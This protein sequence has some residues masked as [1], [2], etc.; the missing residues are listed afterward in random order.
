V[1]ATGKL[2]EPKPGVAEES[3]DR[4]P[5]KSKKKKKKREKK[6]R[7]PE[8]PT[9]EVTISPSKQAAA[10]PRK[11][12]QRASQDLQ[13]TPVKKRAGILGK[14]VASTPTTQSSTPG[15]ES[16]DI[17]KKEPG[18]STPTKQRGGTPGKELTGILKKS[19]WASTPTKQESNASQTAVIETPNGPKTVPIPESLLGPSQAASKSWNYYGMPQTEPGSGSKGHRRKHRESRS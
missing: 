2:D 16:T 6:V 10:T 13:S 3:S 7:A 5:D 11:E 15:G 12:A 9:A 8:S 4:T 17:V 14:Q 19:T 1:A 18:I